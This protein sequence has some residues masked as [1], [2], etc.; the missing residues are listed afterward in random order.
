LKVT[1]VGRKLAARRRP[2]ESDGL[3]L[4]AQG[5]KKAEGTGSRGDAASKSHAEG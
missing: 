4:M 5:M 3:M 2:N 1:K